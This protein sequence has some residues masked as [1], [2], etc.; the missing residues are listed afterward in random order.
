MDLY[1]DQILE[2]Y[3]S[4]HHAGALADPGIAHEEVN[5]SCGDRIRVEA[6]IDNGILRDIGWTG[7]GCAISQAG[8]SMLS[9]AVLGKPV[10]ELL[11]L[12]GKDVLA[13]LGV[14]ISERRL[15]CA[16]LGLHALQNALR[17]HGGLPSQSWSETV[18]SAPPAQ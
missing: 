14:P 16:L 4:P 12:R 7:T 13:L 10:E 8:M 17:T 5:L 9:D 15:K 18:A 3:K 1:A 2:H 11:S 6:Q